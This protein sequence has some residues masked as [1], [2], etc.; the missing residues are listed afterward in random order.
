MRSVRGRDF[1]EDVPRSV[2]VLHLDETVAL[3]SNLQLQFSCRTYTYERGHTNF[4]ELLR[5][6]HSCASPYEDIF[7]DF[8]FFLNT[9]KSK[10]PSD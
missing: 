5:K 4:L 10:N 7:K 3:C 1:P 9:F 6:I 8:G 2:P